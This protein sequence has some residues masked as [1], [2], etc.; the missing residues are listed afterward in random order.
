MSKAMKP[1]VLSPEI[2]D[3]VGPTV[4]SANHVSVQ[5]ARQRQTSIAKIIGG[6]Y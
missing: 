1:L 4:N 2:L 5:P 3:R 6:I